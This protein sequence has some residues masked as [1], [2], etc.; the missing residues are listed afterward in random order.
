M[1]VE[2]LSTDLKFG[3]RGNVTLE[4]NLPKSFFLQTGLAF[5]NKGAKINDKNQSLSANGQ[6]T[7]TTHTKGK[8][9]T[10]YL[11]LPLIGGYRLDVSDYI[12]MNLSLGPYFGYGIGGKTKYT[13]ISEYSSGDTHSTTE[14][15]NMKSF[16]DG[17]LRR[18]DMGLDGNV[19]I[20]YQKCLLN[21]GYE[22]GFIN[23]FKADNVSSYN[24]NF[25]VTLGYRIY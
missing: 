7:I 20:E 12:R 22:Y 14:D 6:T 11:T 16:S 23:Q 4:Y 13:A 17:L 10:N 9:N 1:D 8:Y 15:I 19:G 3:F 25:Y 5:S 21:V 2:R 18:F 24:M